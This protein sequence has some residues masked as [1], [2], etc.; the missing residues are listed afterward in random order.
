MDIKQEP[1]YDVN[2]DGLIY[3]RETGEVIP[4]D[5]PIFI[6]RARDKLAALVISYYLKLC[7]KRK[8]V[9]AIKERLHDFV[10]F[11]HSHPERMKDPD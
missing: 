4:A 5:E 3:N 10:N 6:L 8:F 1:K 9:K 7:S 11:A 2:A